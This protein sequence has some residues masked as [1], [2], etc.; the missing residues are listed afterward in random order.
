[1]ICH[2]PK[3]DFLHLMTINS[4]CCV[5]ESVLKPPKTRGKYSLFAWRDSAGLAHEIWMRNR[6][7]N[8]SKDR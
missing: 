7:R 3:S 4:R 6:E 2:Y 1:V 8:Y 5:L